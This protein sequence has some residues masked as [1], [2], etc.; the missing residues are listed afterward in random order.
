MV[1]NDNTGAYTTWPKQ[2]GT[3]AG[4]TLTAQN[5]LDRS[6]LLFKFALNTRKH[7]TLR[8]KLLHDV[9]KNPLKLHAIICPSTASLYIPN[10][11]TIISLMQ[12]VWVTALRHA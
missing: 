4:L 10:T 8:D 5:D 9:L 11:M 12:R 1:Y 6:R 3:S 2:Y 7:I